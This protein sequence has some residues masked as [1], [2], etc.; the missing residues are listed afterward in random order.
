[1]V[2]TER[3]QMRL[4]LLTTALAFVLLTLVLAGTATAAGTGLPEQ[5][6]ELHPIKG[7]V[8][9]LTRPIRC[10]DRICPLG[11]RGCGCD[12]STEIRPPIRLPI[13]LTAA[14]GA[15]S[16][17]L[18]SGV[19][20][21]TEKSINLISPIRCP[22]VECPWGSAGCGCGGGATGLPTLAE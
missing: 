12:G 18:T 22:D 21:V 1:M 5:E 6:I 2:R 9:E 17:V 15:S 8:I 20:P 10:P 13:E 3:T 14:G 16:S 19:H 11:G 4:V 7:K